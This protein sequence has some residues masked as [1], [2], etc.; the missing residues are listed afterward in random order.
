M[1]PSLSTSRHPTCYYCGSKHHYLLQHS[2][3]GL[4]DGLLGSS[5]ASTDPFP[6]VTYSA[7]FLKCKSDDSVPLFTLQQFPTAHRIKLEFLSEANKVPDVSE[8][9]PWPSLVL[10][11]PGP[12]SSHPVLNPPC[13]SHP[14]VMYECFLLPVITFFFSSSFFKTLCHVSTVQPCEEVFC[15]SYSSFSIYL[16]ISTWNHN[17]LFCSKGYDVLLTLYSAQECSVMILLSL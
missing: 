15:A 8:P 12:C 5:S 3:D 9:T 16:L 7:I 6:H 11:P 13:L 17:F 14:W 4:L 1:S 10:H 2:S